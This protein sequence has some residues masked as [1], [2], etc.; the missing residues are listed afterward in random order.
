MNVRSGPG[1][2]H[3]GGRLKTLM[4][5]LGCCL[6]WG[7]AV[8]TLPVYEKDGRRYGVVEGAFRHRWWNYY[9]RALSY[10]RGGFFGP[11]KADLTHALQQRC[12][13]QRM[14]RTYGMHFVDYF[15]HREL[16]IIH[17][18]AGE[19][20]P[21]ESELETSL[22]QYPS[23]KA[24][25]Y[26]DRVRRALIE[27]SG[28]PVDAPQLRLTLD[29]VS[30][31]IYWSSEDAVIIE[32]RAFDENFVVR[33]SVFG[34]PVFMEGA[35]REVYFKERLMLPPGRHTI[36]VT[37]ENLFGRETRRTLTFQADR[38]G[39]VVTLA[40]A[41]YDRQAAEPY[42][43]IDGW[44]VDAAGVC[45]LDV[46]G[47]TR[48]YDNLSEVRVFEKI[49]GP[50]EDVV[51]TAH[52]RLG[53]RTTAVI[54]AAAADPADRVDAAPL[55]LR[56]AP[57]S[58]RP[59]GADVFGSLSAGVDVMLAALE[60][61]RL[62]PLRLS[63]FGPKDTV[64]P[65]IEL[66]DWTA[67]QTVLVDQIYLEGAAV[68]DE[69]VVQLLINGVSVM[70]REGL[71]VYFG[72]PAH[73]A[74]GDNPFVLE[75]RD[76][77]GNRTVKKMTVTRRIPKVFQNDQRMSM[78]V[79]P[80]EQDG[81]SGL[82]AAHFQ[83]QLFDALWALHRFHLVEREQLEA[84]LNEQKLS[85]TQLVDPRTALQVGKLLT[86]RTL[87]AGS[88][89]SS[90]GGM[91]IVGRLID[92]E[93]SAILAVED[94]FDEITAGD[95]KALKNMS[96]GLA[97]KLYRRFPLLDGRVVQKKGKFIFT[98]LGGEGIDLQ[99]RLV[100]YREEPVLHPVTGKE[101]GKDNVILCRAAVVQVMAG[102]SK[103]EL[104]D[105]CPS[106]IQVKDKV[107]TE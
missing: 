90:R 42:W 70:Q 19:L 71:R 57:P 7:C 43:R 31:K 49:H 29:S 75:A 22:T 98:D 76:A 26:L 102:L 95:L 17:Y 47:R 33:V 82:P 79:L 58:K 39:P 83:N 60:T 107:I 15:P 8:D 20:E 103:A 88:M 24:R 23:A 101:L 35:R 97:L 32:G 51:L 81:A 85:R 25:Y 11:A 21:A 2:P 96:Q 18:E 62:P 61:D 5:V 78:T 52:D 50:L 72:H 34:R 30:E 67:E 64:P 48:L 3:R 86:C 1:W 53:N 13:D 41:I 93:T 89:V 66:K 38:S 106:T 105:D 14:A 56:A 94:V 37:A 65:R 68:D 27:K 36:V 16:G 69:K 55:A 54:P 63:L 28:R 87:L 40:Q 45:R 12:E 99:R 84:V 9:E 80:F 74:E 59:A 91:E 92:A 104:L 4:M 46:N 100:V 6:L 44:V 10:A 77:A 73:L